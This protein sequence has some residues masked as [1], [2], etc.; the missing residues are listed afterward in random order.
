[1]VLLIFRFSHRRFDLGERLE[2]G[3]RECHIDQV[4]WGRLAGSGST[5]ASL[6]AQTLHREGLLGSFDT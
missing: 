6:D 3:D 5:R 2:G 4:D 1:M